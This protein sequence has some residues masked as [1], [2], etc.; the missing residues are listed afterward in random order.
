MKKSHKSLV[1]KYS[2]KASENRRLLLLCGV[3][4]ILV[5]LIFILVFSYR[6]R[7]LKAEIEESLIA[8][9]I[10]ES[11]SVKASIAQSVEESLAEER[12]AKLTDCNDYELNQLV[13]RY[14]ECRQ[15]GDSSGLFE[16][17]GRSDTSSNADLD[18]LLSV[19]A[20]WIRSFDDIYVYTLNGPDEDSVIGVVKYKI[21]FRRVTSKAPCIMYFYA[22]K[23]D[24]TWHMCEN[25]LKDT[26]DFIE[27]AF[28]E[29]GVNNLINENKEELEKV[30]ASDS[31]LALMY[32]SF[33]NGEIYD[34]TVLDPDREQTIE[35]F[36]DPADSIL[37]D[38]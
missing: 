32:T 23:T 38:N 30:L 9:S 31:G 19:Q 22:E 37:I 7:V 1:N 26:R 12:K 29:S 3:A 28:E 2:R 13:K 20:Q 8:E 10:E 24:G 6:N 35:L 14:F 17:F 33:M 15:A 25:L 21:N 5:L 11:E 18:Y 27:N 16:I 36:A 4:L 34:E